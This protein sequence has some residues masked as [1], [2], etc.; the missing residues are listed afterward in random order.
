[1]N[2]T[3]TPN[4]IVIASDPAV[5]QALE[6]AMGDPPTNPACVV[7]GHGGP[8][9]DEGVRLWLQ[10]LCSKDCHKGAIS[11]LAFSDR[12]L[13]GC[14]P[15]F[16]KHKWVGVADVTLPSILPQWP[17]RSP[18]DEE[19]SLL[20]SDA[21]D[22]ILEQDARLLRHDFRGLAAA[23]R[24]YLGALILGAAPVESASNVLKDLRKLMLAPNEG[25][26]RKEFESTFIEHLMAFAEF[27][28]RKLEAGGIQQIHR[29]VIMLDDHA[30]DYG[31]RRIMQEIVKSDVFAFKYW[32]VPKSFDLGDPIFGQLRTRPKSNKKSSN[33]AN[34]NPT[35]MLL[36]HDLGEGHATGLELLRTVRSGVLDVP[37]VFMTA[38]D[39]AE[40]AQWALRGGA[41]QFFAKQLS[42]TGDRASEDYF[43]HFRRVIE[44]MPEEN[45]VRVLWRT[46]VTKWPIDARVLLESCKIPPESDD[47]LEDCRATIE[48]LLDMAFYVLFAYLDG[49]A[50]WFTAGGPLPPTSRER[51]RLA[52]EV[53]ISLVCTCIAAADLGQRKAL[54]IRRDIISDLR[55]GSV[56]PMAECLRLLQELLRVF[57]DRPAPKDKRLQAPSLPE[58]CPDTIQ[59]LIRDTAGE[60]SAASRSQVDRQLI[61]S[62]LLE[63]STE[64]SSVKVLVID[65]EAYLSGWQKAML[66][67]F[68]EATFRSCGD[69]LE[70]THEYDCI[71]LDL[72][73][74]HQESGLRRLNRLRSQDPGVP[75]V[76]MSTSS[77]SLPVIR[78]LKQGAAGF[79]PKYLTPGTSSPKEFAKRLIETVEEAAL[80]G[81]HPVRE[82][83]QRWKNLD[84][85]SRKQPSAQVRELFAKIESKAKGD[86]EWID[87]PEYGNWLA[88]I[89]RQVHMAL[90]VAN[91]SAFTFFAGSESRWIQSPDH[92]RSSKLGL[93]DELAV[94]RLFSWIICPIAEHLAQWLYCLRTNKA[95]EEWQWGASS[96]RTSRP[97]QNP[98]SMN[99]WMK[100]LGNGSNQLNLARSTDVPTSIE[101]QFNYLFDAIND[102]DEKLESMAWS[103]RRN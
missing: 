39:D 27:K 90:L 1:M 46:Y 65:D 80:L 79:L 28:S 95:M 50:W 85:Q 91:R 18:N 6:L 43:D 5:G 98:V 58:G 74:G 14:F 55:H 75:I 76:V 51:E 31:W 81:R 96:E 42:D 9:G 89:S 77:E 8:S 69:Q 100:L 60:G 17:L 83:W 67:V 16:E 87:L 48:T 15:P 29:K 64:T 36:D 35:I 34:N 21:F 88:S 41:N 71:L 30:K 32:N 23:V 49:M 86:G 92:W 22:L 53:T 62:Q 66:K 102:F 59:S 7:Y 78:A 44:P 4:S 82:V 94:E 47:E 97:G 93:R 24:V 54:R 61:L 56:L 19:W 101:D 73:L 38:T 84:D 70:S 63:G 68:P 25:R 52:K 99:A 12:C 72:R 45:E 57:P 37:I 3:E 2:E 40:L 13:S 103:V 26:A 10:W 20:R 11:I 33:P